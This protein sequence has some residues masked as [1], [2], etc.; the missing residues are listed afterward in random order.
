[1][2]SRKLV[3]STPEGLR[4]L[5]EF[6]HL[7]HLLVAGYNSEE[8]ANIVLEAVSNMDKYQPLVDTAFTLIKEKYSWNARAHNI[9]EVLNQACLA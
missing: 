2:A 9:A 1:F 7:E 5:E 4:G 6:R 3:I 8:F